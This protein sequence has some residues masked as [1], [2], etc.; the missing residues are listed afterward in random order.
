MDK[1]RE[2]AINLANENIEFAGN[3]SEYREQLDLSCQT[4]RKQGLFTQESFAKANKDDKSLI[5][6]NRTG[7][8]VPVV[9]PIENAPGLN[10]N[11]FQAH[12]PYNCYFLSSAGFDASEAESLA[13]H[14]ASNINPGC[15]FFFEHSVLSDVNVLVVD[16]IM[17]FLDAQNV[18]YILNDFS[19]YSQ[20]IKSENLKQASMVLYSGKIR[21]ADSVSKK[22][23]LTKDLAMSFGQG[24]ES[25][26]ID[27]DVNEG[28][29]ILSGK[30]IKNNHNI[31][32]EMWD[33]YKQRFME[34][35]E[36]YPINL[37][38]TF[39]E[40]VDM[41]TDNETI[42]AVAYQEGRVACFTYLL[43]NNNKANW[44][45]AES[46]QKFNNPN[47]DLYYF[48]GIVAHKD[49]PG[50]S[51]EVLHAIARACKQNSI[52]FNILFECTNH[53]ATYIP[54]IISKAAEQTGYINATTCAEE[55]TFYKILQ[56]ID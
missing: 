45:N 12:H 48:P 25:G 18:D 9:T 46:L 40:F 24:V 54:S 27:L 41:I 14:I 38:D 49:M 6:A 29:E 13:Q 53:S 19:Q 42:V 26:D 8:N 51:M 37:E 23:T 16:K 15:S 50:K 44:L 33:V 28:S 10:N 1:I 5:V 31:L 2:E 56:V 17:K 39:E 35:S 22:R 30:S 21:L 36:N 7:F 55:Q 52:E 47:F 32:S 43:K 34:I 3:Y 20:D 11:Y 4:S